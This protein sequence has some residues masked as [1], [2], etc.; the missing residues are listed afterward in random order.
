[1]PIKTLGS[2]GKIRVGRVTGNTH[3]FFFGLSKCLFKYFNL[4]YCFL[5]VLFSCMNLLYIFYMYI[6]EERGGL[7]VNAPNSGSRGRGFKPHSGRT[8]LCPLARHIHSPKVLVIPRKQWLRP[9]L[10]E[11]LFTRT[12]R[13]NQPTCKY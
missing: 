13:I 12:L 8:V 7:V 3:I 11:K 10:T 4:F 5:I 9:N 2:L 1:M 6:Y